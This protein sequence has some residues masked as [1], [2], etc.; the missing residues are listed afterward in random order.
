MEMLIETGI[1]PQD[2]LST[3]IQEANELIAIFTASVKTVRSNGP[4]KT[5]K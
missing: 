5:S 2:R 1:V 3:L 4:R